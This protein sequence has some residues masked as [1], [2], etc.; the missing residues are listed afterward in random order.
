M[1]LLIPQLLQSQSSAGVLYCVT[2]H[3]VTLVC[4][5][6]ASDIMI[7][8]G[9]DNDHGQLGYGDRRAVGRFGYD[10]DLPLPRPGAMY[11]NLPQDNGRIV[12][13]GKHNEH[14]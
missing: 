14:E 7:C 10:D 1:Q 4:R 13:M 11:V 6:E 2:L 5:G 12:S 9:A 8:T 3:C